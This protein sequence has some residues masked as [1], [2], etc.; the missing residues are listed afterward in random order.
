[1][2]PVRKTAKPTLF[3]KPYILASHIRNEDHKKVAQI[4][5][6]QLNS[7]SYDP[8]TL[9]NAIMGT[10]KYINMSDVIDSFETLYRPK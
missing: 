3:L 4:A 2:K 6:S 7:Y 8:Y 9:S 10:S 5:K 1:M